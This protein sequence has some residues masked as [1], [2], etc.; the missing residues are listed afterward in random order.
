MTRHFLDLT[1]AGGDA[2]SAMLND[3]LGRVKSGMRRLNGLADAHIDE[4]LQ[5]RGHPAQLDSQC[6]YAVVARGQADAY[7]R[8]P[9]RADYVEKIWDHAAGALI[10]A[11]AGALVS[12]IHGL[13]LDYT[14]G[15]TLKRNRG[16]VCAVPSFHAPILS[17]IST[18]YD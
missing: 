3:A 9:T 1:D 16:I 7:I 17:A 18:L 6:K 13:A 11:E 8:L 2:I 12:D 14:Q 5:A 15:A 4:Y 10:A